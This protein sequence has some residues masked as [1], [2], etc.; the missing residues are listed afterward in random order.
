H[1]IESFRNQLWPGYKTGEA[2]EPALKNQFLFLEDA[3]RALGVV[4]WPM[5][6]VEAD[7]ALASAAAIAARDN[8]VDR[9]LICTPDKDLAQCVVGERVVQ[10]HR[11]RDEVGVVDEAGVRQR[12]G[13]EPGTI[14]DYLALVGDSADGFPGL[15]G[16]GAKSAAAVLACYRHL[17][18]IP[19]DPGKWEVTVRGSK[20][21]AA[22]LAAQRDLAHLFKTLATLRVDGSLLDSVD[23]ASGAASVSGAAGASGASGAVGGTESLRWAGPTPDLAAVCERL[24]SPRMLA[25]AQA[26]AQARAQ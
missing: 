2:I 9:V 3:L 10:L 23:S 4:V 22:T 20:A 24:G 17:E 5:V 8:R 15:S 25:R 11:R 18:H 7:D 19:D 6:E 1:V 21:L 14:P 16:W 12:V 13:V 26:L